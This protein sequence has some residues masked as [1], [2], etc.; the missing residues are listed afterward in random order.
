ML[1]DKK[2]RLYCNKIFVMNII[3]M[4][5]DCKT[6]LNELNGHFIRKADSFNL[7]PAWGK[8]IQRLPI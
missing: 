6:I 1:L 8:S 3:Q 2:P 5:V 7:S 4:H